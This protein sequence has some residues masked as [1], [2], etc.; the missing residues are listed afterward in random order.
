[1]RFGSAF[2]DLR[3]DSQLPFTYP[4]FAALV[5]RPFA[6]MS[7][8]QLR[9][10]SILCSI[11]LLTVS[12]AL[13]VRATGDRNRRRLVFVTLIATVVALRLEPIEQTLSLGQVNI[14]LMA[15][16]LVDLLALPER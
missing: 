8:D 15:L 1:M 13:A 11:V 14:F 9:L 4:P 3:F 7:I 5:F 16:V 10:L 6:G 2:Y 12:N